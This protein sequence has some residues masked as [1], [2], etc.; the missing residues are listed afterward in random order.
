MIKFSIVTF[1]LSATPS[2]YVK[3]LDIDKL[4]SKNTKIHTDIKLENNTAILENSGIFAGTERI[5]TFDGGVK[6]LLIRI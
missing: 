3:F 6:I 1:D 5:A 4:K 2:G